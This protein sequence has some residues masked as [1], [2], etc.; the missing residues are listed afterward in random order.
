MGSYDYWRTTLA[1]RPASMTD[2]EPGYGFYYYRKVKNG[3]RIAVAIY[4]NGLDG[5]T[6]AQVDGDLIDDPDKV[7]DVWM[8][9]ARHPIS[10]KLYRARMGLGHWP[11]EAQMPAAAGPA[12]QLP[13]RN[14]PQ[15]PFEALVAEVADYVEHADLFLQSNAELKDDV[16]GD[17]A[18]NM[19]KKL[20]DL[21]KRADGLHEAEKAPHLAKCRE[22]DGKYSE[23]RERIAGMA[24][25]LRAVVT[26]YL[27][28]KQ[29]EADEAS[30][31]EAARIAA[32]VAA[33]QREATNDADPSPPPEVFV[34]AQRVKAGGAFGSRTGLRK[35][36][37]LVIDDY[38]QVLNATRDHPL[39]KD[40]VEKAANAMVKAGLS[41]PGV[42]IHEQLV[43]A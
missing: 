16:A 19:R 14:E 18:A 10:E 15:D 38:E 28:R 27:N 32:E 37:K 24:E 3:P 26:A 41:V 23:I 1:G 13:L 25:R 7:A 42:S 43:A 8:R 36:K 5:V 30:R 4:A 17:K 31:K 9:C 12:P 6:V 39:V 11:D 34:P 40:A 2:A 21:R 35:T 33:R 22:V 29:R 20:I